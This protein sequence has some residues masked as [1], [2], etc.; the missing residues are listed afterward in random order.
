MTVWPRARL[1][2]PLHL[3]RRSNRD[4]K[5]AGAAKITELLPAGLGCTAVYVRADLSEVADCKAV[6]A[7]PSLWIIPTVSLLL[8]ASAV[9]D[10]HC[11]GRGAF[12]LPLPF[13]TV[14][15]WPSTALPCSFTAFPCFFIA[16]FTASR[17][18][19]TAVSAAIPFG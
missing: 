5:S 9:S 12:L 8:P 11:S 4:G 7:V 19:R 16:C 3:S 2:P 15:P 1:R 14:F 13:L 6:V 18:W 10:F 17:R